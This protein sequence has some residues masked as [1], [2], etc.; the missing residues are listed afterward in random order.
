MHLKNQI[1]K[2][3]SKEKE[4]YRR[5]IKRNSPGAYEVIS[6]LKTQIETLQKEI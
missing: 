1:M 2:E 3:I 4:N 5:E 6:S